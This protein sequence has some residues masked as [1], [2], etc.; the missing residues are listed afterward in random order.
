MIIKFCLVFPKIFLLHKVVRDA[1]KVE[2]HCVR[3]RAALCDWVFFQIYIISNWMFFKQCICNENCIWVPIQW[4]VPIR[5]M[6]CPVTQAYTNEPCCT[7]RFTLA[8]QSE[9]EMPFASSFFIVGLL[10]YPFSRASLRLIRQSLSC[11]CFYLFL[12]P[13]SRMSSLAL[14][15]MSPSCPL[16]LRIFLNIIHIRLNISWSNGF[17]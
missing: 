8:H 17:A 5:T 6:N 13:F 4:T 1:K 7:Q 15:R 3:A 9:P 2:K 16:R 12:V 11:S 14:Q 10:S